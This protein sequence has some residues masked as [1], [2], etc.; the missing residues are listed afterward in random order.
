MLY[1]PAAGARDQAGLRREF[2]ATSHPEERA[3]TQFE[4]AGALTNV[5]SPIYRRTIP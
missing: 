1:A 3:N 5:F 4:K 2:E